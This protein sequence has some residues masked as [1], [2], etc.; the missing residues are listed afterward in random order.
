MDIHIIYS[1]YIKFTISDKKPAI[2][3]NGH[4]FYVRLSVAK[5]MILIYVTIITSDFG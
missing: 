1:T 2:A 5:A 3:T 4:F